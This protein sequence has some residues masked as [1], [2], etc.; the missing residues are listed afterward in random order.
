[1]TP[2]ANRFAICKW[3]FPSEPYRR[4]EALTY[5]SCGRMA[6]CSGW[7]L[8]AVA[9]ME[10]LKSTMLAVRDAKTWRVGSL[11]STMTVER[12]RAC[13]TKTANALAAFLIG[14]PQ[15]PRTQT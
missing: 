7:C 3:S 8:W 15:A 2:E 14:F 6:G 11:E 13:P 10:A 1:M 12:Q 4:I 5:E 9:S